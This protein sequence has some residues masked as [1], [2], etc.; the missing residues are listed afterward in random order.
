M[1]DSI[2]PQAVTEQL[3]DLTPVQI[4]LIEA[5]CASDTVLTACKSVGLSR[6][7]YY[8]WLETP[9]F[10]TAY[11]AVKT[12]LLDEATLNLVKL[13]NRQIAII[14]SISENEN[15]LPHIRS[16]A[17][18]KLLRR[19]IDLVGKK[20]NVD[21]RTAVRVEVVYTDQHGQTNDTPDWVEGVVDD[22]TD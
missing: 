1:S 15:N 16:E 3:A 12:A 21:K 19:L 10:A 2:I 5:L 7:A 6:G 22:A 18:D 9:A 20:I 11:E 8:K 4:R 13:A 14:A 17:A